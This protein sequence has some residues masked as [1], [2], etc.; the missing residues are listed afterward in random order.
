MN[1]SKEYTPPLSHENQRSRFSSPL[2][3]AR[4]ALPTKDSPRAALRNLQL[5]FTATWLDWLTIALI[6]ATAAGVWTAPHTFTRL[7]PVSSPDGTVYWPELAY[8]YIEP[9]FS[10]ALAGIL[11]ALIPILVFAI[12]QIWQQSFT[13][14]ASAV[15]G[16]AYSMVTG[17][18]FQVIL[19]KTVG[20]LRPHL[21]AVCM[22][23]FP[24]RDG[25]VGTGYM[26][27]MYTAEKLCTGD[28]AKIGNALES[29]PSGHSNIAFAG[30]GYLSIYLFTHLLL[31]ARA[32][33][34]SYWRMLF[35]IA[36]LLLASYLV[37]TLVLG[38]HH[39][40]YDVIAGSIIGWIMAFLGYR[41]VFMGV[42]D[43]RWNCVPYLRL[44]IGDVDG[45][46]EHE[47]R[48]RFGSGDTLQGRPSGDRMMEMA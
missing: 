10:A 30:F 6:G 25:S 19:K 43:A 22:P 48:E 9:I 3:H 16:L 35:V 20:G 38:Y 24:P 26:G 39:H 14:F 7:F 41:M 28:M 17:T 5:F 45:E 1:I 34:A 23:V 8:P 46:D 4:A 31:N 27:M 13:D 44:R 21:M 11:A 15:L 32:R 29:F 36:P 18:C 40:G 12:A 47:P 37:S 2:H 42:L 33:R